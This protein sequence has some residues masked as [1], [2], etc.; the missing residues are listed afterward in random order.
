M[1]MKLD[2]EVKQT[3]FKIMTLKTSQKI[4]DLKPLQFLYGK[5]SREFLSSLL[6]VNGTLPCSDDKV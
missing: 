5:V 4:T 6:N 2:L 3:D 1:Q